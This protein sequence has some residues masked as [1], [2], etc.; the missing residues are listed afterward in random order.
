MKYFITALLFLLSFSARADFMDGNDLYKLDQ[1]SA[2]YF[3]IGVLDNSNMYATPAVKYCM[4]PNV[5][6]G[7]ARDV[8]FKYL[9]EFP[10]FRQNSAALITV[11]AISKAWP[12]AK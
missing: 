1:T 10:E 9:R 5:T 4:P 11:F 7:Q 8:V 2:A 3:V 6:S 12:C